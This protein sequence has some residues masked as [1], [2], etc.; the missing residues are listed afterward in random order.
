MKRK[1]SRV[2][3]G[4]SQ[5][6]TPSRTNNA[7]PKKKRL[8]GSG[9][10]KGD[11]IRVGIWDLGAWI[12]YLDEILLRWNNSQKMFRF[13]SVYLS[14]PVQL[15][16]GGARTEQVG[17]E[18]DIAPKLRHV[19]IDNLLIESVAAISEKV[20]SGSS[21]DQLVSITPLMLA[22]IEGGKLHYNY[23]STSQAG[24]IFVSA[25]GV[26]GYAKRAKRPYEAAIAAL[27]LGQLLADKSDV[28]EFHE[29]TRGCLFDFN[30][31]R[32]TLVRM[33]RKMTIEPSCL[34]KIPDGLRRA[35]EQM[36]KVI[37]EYRRPSK[38]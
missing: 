27:I 34:E 8:L 15:T 11:V 4:P 16:R 14:V 33:L 6:P 9:S 21:Y 3:R 36:L 29:E 17:N 19:L 26:E 20:R 38:K 37:A 24:S 12:G 10:P 30:E 1:Q 22:F 31:D 32:D 7:A 25:Y 28:I 5:P 2:Y 35:G 23:Y 18:Y 13:E